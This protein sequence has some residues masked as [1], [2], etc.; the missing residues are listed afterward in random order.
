MTAALKDFASLA[1]ALRDHAERLAKARAAERRAGDA[2][3]GSKW[4]SA[5]L[6]W[7]DLAKE[8]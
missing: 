2:R 3:H 5:P 7:P 1:E 8:R 4:R 6:L